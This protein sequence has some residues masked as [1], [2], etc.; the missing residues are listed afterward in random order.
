MTEAILTAIL[1]SS[2]NFLLSIITAYYAYKKVFEK[3]SNIVLSSMV[4]RYIIAASFVWWGLSHFK[5]NAVAF[6]VCFMISTFIFIFFEIFFFIY[7]S[8]FVILH[9]R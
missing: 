8:K 5:E 9:K 1:I 3:F 7:Y 4:I 2:G 6:G